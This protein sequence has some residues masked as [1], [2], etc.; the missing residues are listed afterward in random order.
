[1]VKYIFLTNLEIYRLL[2][3]LLSQGAEFSEDIRSRYFCIMINSRILAVK[4]GRT[5]YVN[6]DNWGV[7]DA[8]V[9]EEL[10]PKTIT[11]G[12]YSIKL[13]KTYLKDNYRNF[14]K[15]FPPL[16]NDVNKVIKSGYN[17]GLLYARPG[18]YKQKVYHYDI[19]AA[20]G[21]AFKEADIPIGPPRKIDGYVKPD[22]EHLHIYLAELN[23][24]F[25]SQRIFPY[26]VNSS[27]IHKMP[28][29]IVENTGFSSLYK[30]ITETEFEDLKKDYMVYHT[31]LYTL[32]F[33]KHK[34]LFD[35]F[36]DELY[37][38]RHA[39]YGDEQIIWKTVLASL[40][41]KF[42]QEITRSQKPI[43]IDEFG[44]IIYT[45]SNKKLDDVTY[46]SPQVSLFVVDYV[47][48]KLRDTIKEVGYKNVILAD[49]DGFISL[50]PVDVPLS[51]KLGDWK[52]TEYENI[53]VNGTR[54]YLYTENGEFH[55]SISG[56]GDIFN[57]GLNQ[58]SY[59][60]IYHISKL[61]RSIPVT[62][63][64]TVNGE[65]KYTQM[66]INIGGKSK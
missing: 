2:R 33:K 15:L 8:S 40:A 12:S 37:D 58:Y 9:L 55:S 47:R 34:G 66:N 29:Q 16:R 19:N 42:S 21:E 27:D 14:S 52:V 56:L 5:W 45:T 60:S 10:N 23:V 13:L 49:T 28:S 7:K 22:G 30:V 36:I 31:I 43:G 57:D 32:Q 11:P 35:S 4:V 62:K 51:K 20:Y 26:L 3:K 1:M 25:N 53:I 6:I 50:I 39:T 48:K 63:K 59:D 24:E 18:F 38:K 46:I 54:S 44:G 64:V 61:K 41:G 65:E 17:S